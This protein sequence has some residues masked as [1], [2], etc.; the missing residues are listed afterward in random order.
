P[1]TVKSNV[2][3]DAIRN[4]IWGVDAHYRTD[5]R[6]LTEMVDRIPLIQTKEKSEIFMEG[7]F[8]QNIPGHAKLQ[9][10]PNGT[11]GVSYL[12]DFEGSSVPYDLRLTSNWFISSIPMKQPMRFPEAQFVD[13]LSTGYHRARLSWYTIDNVMFQNSDLAPPNVRNNVGMLSDPY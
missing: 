13:S 12:D 2:G 7:E 9:N 11:G 5:S 10:D 6:L 8:A 3:D 1:L 4:A